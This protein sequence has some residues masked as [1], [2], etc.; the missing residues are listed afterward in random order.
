[1]EVEKTIKSSV[2][3]VLNTLLKIL[4]FI[5]STKSVL[6]KVSPDINIIIQT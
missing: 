2:V 3:L 1:M 6:Y 4:A 5:V